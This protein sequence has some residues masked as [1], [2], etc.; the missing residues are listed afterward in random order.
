M[1]PIFKFA[2]VAIASVW[3]LSSCQERIEEGARFTFVG[4]TIATYLESDEEQFS[5]F[6]EILTRGECLGLMKAYGQYTCFAPTNEAVA[7]FLEEQ[8]A[9]YLESIA[10]GDT[11]ETG[12]HSANLSDLSEEKCREIA[13]NHILPKMYLGVDLI[14]NQIPEANMNDRNLTLEFDTINGKPVAKI[15]STAPVLYEE[16][17]ENGVVHTISGVLNPS[18]LGVSAQIGEYDYFTIFHEAFDEGLID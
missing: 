17:V 12:I 11:I 7:S 16:E 13:R 1:K 9:I 6:V 2:A 10:T 4:K 15:N 18:T 8:S 14:G 3:A 5:S